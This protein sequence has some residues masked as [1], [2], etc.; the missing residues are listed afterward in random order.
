MIDFTVPEETR[1]TVDG[2]L[3]FVQ[4]EVVPLEEANRAL[5]DDPHAAHTPDG[6]LVP[7]IV[8][9]RRQVRMVSARAGY[10]TLFAPEDLGGA[11]KGPIT[12]FLV[13]EALYHHAGAD[14]LLPYESVAHW[15]TGVSPI[16]R[17]LR[18]EARAVVLPRLLSGEHTS[19]FALSEPDAGS[20]VWSMKTRAVRDG[21]DYVIDGTKQWISYAPYAQHAVLF[22]V[23][24]PDQLARRSGGISCFLVDTGTPGFSVDSVIRLFGHVGGNEAILS[25]TNMRVPAD[26]LIGELDQGFRSALGGVN[27]GRLYNC[28]RAVGL[29]RW[30]LERAT[31]YAK[32]RVTFGH[33]IAEYQGVQWLLADSAME[34][35]AARMMG[36]N[37]AWRLEQGE[38]A[39]K[40]TAMIKAFATEAG[41]RTLDRCMQV[42]GGMGLTNEMKL[43]D[44]WHQIRVVRIAD[45]SAEIMR[46]TI[47]QRLLKGDLGF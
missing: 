27:T 1:L 28:A 20:D 38:P 37:C 39:I 46:R 13:W 47:A 35:Y 3:S 18:N 44:A 5:L 24:D 4:R 30:A 7:E 31:H 43:F 9:L 17:G 32:Q 10:Y 33:P 16:L 8:E 23:T 34:I 6:R 41:F 2:L 22:A 11:G 42:F 19:C 40:E 29:S 36:L 12:L 25:F 26:R 15:V 45:G 14:R 21:D